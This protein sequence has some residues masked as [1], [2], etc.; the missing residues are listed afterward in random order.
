MNLFNPRA[1]VAGL[2]CLLLTSLA[3][4]SATL[5]TEKAPDIAAIP[6]GLQAEQKAMF[7]KQLAGIAELRTAFKTAMADYNNTPRSGIV[8]GSSQEKELN[9]K[10]ATVNLSRAN[11][12]SAVKAFNEAMAAERAAMKTRL[13]YIKMMNNHVQGL[14]YWDQKKKDRVNAALHQL[15]SDGDLEATSTQVRDA[16]SHI[17]A[18]DSAKDLAAEAA[19]GEG[20]GFPGAG[21]Q[22]HEDCAVFALANAA[23][24]PYGL[25]AA[26]AADLIGKAGWRPP[27]ERSAPERTIARRGLNGG[28]V[29]ILAETFGQATVVPSK[30]FAAALGKGGRILVNVFPADGD[31]EGGHEIVLTKTFQHDG[32]TWFAVMDSNQA[33]DKMLYLSSK[34]LHTILQEN[35]VLFQP[36]PNRTVPLL[37]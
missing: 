13:R 33:P 1:F 28:E 11:Y 2:I 30:D 6:S 4:H 23:G 7:E 18:R 32:E 27:E 35:G 21:T 12:I 29:I 16:W 14:E 3:A 34:E 5:S 24:L 10:I 19:Q 20:P 9:L 36:E 8:V 37:R 22:S 26:R 17:L 25:V 31:L 15:E